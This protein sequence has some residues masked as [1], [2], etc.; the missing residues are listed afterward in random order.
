MT[1]KVFSGYSRKD[2]DNEDVLCKDNEA[3]SSREIVCEKHKCRKYSTKYP[4]FGFTN[5]DADGEEAA[6]LYEKFWLQTA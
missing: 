2:R 5:S 1:D 4:C 6:M 3:S